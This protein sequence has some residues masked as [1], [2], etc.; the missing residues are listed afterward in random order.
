MKHQ[1]IQIKNNSFVLRFP[2]K[3]G[4]ISEES[5]CFLHC[6]LG[7]SEESLAETLLTE[8]RY[9]ALDISNCL[10][11]GYDGVASVSG[12]VNDLSAYILKIND[13]AV[14]IHCHSHRLYLAEASSCNIKCA[15]NTLD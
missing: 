3:D 14:Y 2:D 10:V 4:E 8:I 9:L 13:K 7:L 5:L 15:R 11:D 1:L 6:E 12:H